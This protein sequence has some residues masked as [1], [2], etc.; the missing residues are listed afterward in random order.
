MELEFFPRSESGNQVLCTEYSMTLLPI[1]QTSQGLKNEEYNSSNPNIKP[2]TKHKI[3]KPS[4]CKE[5]RKTHSSRTQ[6]RHQPTQFL[7]RFRISDRR[8]RTWSTSSSPICLCLCEREL[9]EVI[10]WTGDRATVRS[11]GRAW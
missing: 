11:A 2:S 5:T 6:P 3:V 8:R 4:Q 1:H 7:I 9:G 10:L